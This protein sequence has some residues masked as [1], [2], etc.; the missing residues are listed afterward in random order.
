MTNIFKRLVYNEQKDWFNKNNWSIFQ[1][2]L[3]S[4]GATTYRYPQTANSG[5]EEKL[6]FSGNMSEPW[7]K[8]GQ[9]IEGEAPDDFFG[10]SV[11]MSAD[12]SV[13]AIGATKNDGDNG[14]NSGHVRVY[15]YDD[16]D[17]LWKQIGEDIDGEAS[18]DESGQSVSLSADGSIVAI[19][20]P[21]NGGDNGDNSGHVR[22]YE[23]D[24]SSWVKRGANID[25]EA[26]GDNSGFSVSLSADGSIVAI[27]APFNN[28]NGQTSGHVRVYKYNSSSWEQIGGDIDGE[29]GGDDSGFSVSLSADGS[30]VAIGAPIN[31]G[32][33]GLYS[34]HVRVYRRNPD[35]SQADEDGPIGWDRMGGDIDGES[36]FD[37][38]GQSVALSA[39]GSIVAIGA[40]NNNGGEYSGHVR[41]YE[42][43]DHSSLWEQ[44]GEDINGEAVD[45]SGYSVSLSADGSIVA[46]GSILDGTGNDSGHVRLYQYDGSSWEKIGE[47]IDGEAS[48]DRSGYSVSLSADG[49]IVAI[50]AVGDDGNG[51][52][53]GHV[54][55]YRHN[56]LAGISQVNHFNANPA[57]IAR[58]IMVSRNGPQWEKVGADIDGEA[59]GDRSGSSI[60]LS[61]DGMVMAIASPYNA[62]NG[63]N[64]GEVRIFQY[65]STNRGWTLLGNPILGEENTSNFS[66][67]GETF[68]YS[69]SLS[70]NG[71][72]IVVGA[73]QNDQY[74]GTVRTYKYEDRDGVL[75]WH[76]IGEDIHGAN[77][78]QFGSSV[79][80]SKN[81]S[82]IAI[83]DYSADDGGI[84]GAGYVKVYE[85]V[86]DNWHQIGED[87]LGEPLVNS[88]SGYSISLNDI[89]SIV[90]IGAIRA[91]DE[92]NQEVGHVRVFQFKKYTQD[93]HNDSKYNYQNRTIN[94]QFTKPIIMTQDILTPPVVGNEYWTQN[95][96]DID[97][98]GETGYSVSLSNNGKIVAIGSTVSNRVNVYRYNGETW[99]KIGDDIQGESGG[100]RAGSSVSLSSDG[101][102]VA[103]GA[104]HNDGNGNN[105][106][107]VRVY[108]N[109]NDS[110]VKMGQ[111]IDGEAE[112]DQ[113]GNSV[114]LSANGS[115]VAIG[116]SLNDGNRGHVRVYQI[117][118]RNPWVQQGL[119]IVDHGSNVI[120]QNHDSWAMVSVSLSNDGK[121]LA[122]GS[123]LNDG[124]HGN[125]QDT[126]LVRVFENTDG[127]W[128]Q[129]GSDIYGEAEGDQKGFS[130]S[131][132]ADGSKL[133]VGATENDNGYV[134]VY[135]F[136][137]TN[138]NWDQVG[139]N[140][141][142]EAGGDNSGFSV[143]LS[144]DGSI[145][146]IGAPFN[147][148]NGQTSGHVRVYKYNSSSW[149]QLGGDIDGE[150]ERDG[151]GYAVSLSADG[152][153]V[154]IGAPNNDGGGYGE[155]GHVRIYQ[156]TPNKTEADEDG[157]IGWSKLGGDIDG[158]LSFSYNGVTV[159]L[160]ADG[161]IVAIGSPGVGWAGN[162]PYTRIYR[163]NPDKSEADE[164]G[165]IGWDRMGGDING[166]AVDD[167]GLSVSLSGDG[168]IVAIGAPF[169]DGNGDDSGHVRIYQHTPN[170]T[171]ADEDGPIGWSILGRDIDGEE[172][173][174]HSGAAV[175]LSSD[176]S[177]VAIGGPIKHT[178]ESDDTP[179]VR[180][181]KFTGWGLGSV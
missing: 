86:D 112:G 7:Q 138:N 44:I 16:D 154:A 47:D 93:D 90:A 8:I 32:D 100:D 116:A 12:G 178:L 80:I 85:I 130:V 95:G 142:G 128:K 96:V 70:G 180:V 60:S 62:N 120:E 136:N 42:Y 84:T 58:N 157:P 176:G 132:S 108:Q 102:V 175:S 88:N 101:L 161:S 18:G 134:R 119:D 168:S 179:R 92:D 4:K 148:G 43:N 40:I 114:S 83:G 73:P 55:V 164:D 174:Y 139:A 113:S 74:S 59:T 17:S 54:R 65:T 143:S 50:G 67:K 57:D 107:H 38:S 147:N 41:V 66:F 144:A 97:G 155:S 64:S 145:V 117:A 79:S 125:Q 78:D 129:K 28:G 181:Y 45:E 94:Q 118:K 25:G 52:N 20:A 167:P 2:H 91:K 98:G 36:T 10:Y 22:V 11:S 5:I 149:Q 30:I 140:I 170:K 51:N 122:I 151:S 13:M 104:T 166:E 162:P 158:D 99:Q 150:A 19:G 165:P 89:G 6:S 123:R 69:V 127:L 121:V 46:I 106:G 63:S 35:K 124:N 3:L 61:A 172:A 56:V 34:G 21:I 137:L 26:G 14:D 103:I 152:S 15:A 146:A 173:N 9:D 37:F 33:N 71:S 77:Q 39:D 29:A 131:L 1:D 133:A 135:E 111:N 72:V 53:S 23:F 87:I 27:G 163:S 109:V 105:S 81:G 153:V 110:W 75:D 49:S 48:G 160:S 177:T 171:E 68:G 24:G 141:D 169:N 159:A 82:V 76:Q 115:V 31:G 156:H 126:G